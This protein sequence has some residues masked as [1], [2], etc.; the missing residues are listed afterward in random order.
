MVCY[1]IFWSG[2][3]VERLPR[4]KLTALGEKTVNQTVFTKE[5]IDIRYELAEVARDKRFANPFNRCSGDP[6]KYFLLRRTW[7]LVLSME[8]I[9]SKLGHDWWNETLN[10]G[11]NLRNLSRYVIAA[12]LVDGNKRSLI[13]SFCLSTSICLFH[14]CYLCLPRL[15]ENH[16]LYY[17]FGGGLRSVVYV[18][19]L[20]EKTSRY[21]LRVFWSL[22]P[23]SK[24]CLQKR[25]L[26][27]AVKAMVIFHVRCDRWCLYSCD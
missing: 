19:F 17:S 20:Q 21:S 6:R 4:E 7:R 13:S 8:R 16:L 15:H 11:M 12:M 26:V 1:G 3:V 10:R 24:R 18:S 25:L 14:H 2:Q 22:G 27:S 5:R 23:L 9:P